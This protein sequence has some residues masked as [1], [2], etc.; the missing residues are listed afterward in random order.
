MAKKTNK[1]EPQELSQPESNIPFTFTW[2]GELKLND[3]VIGKYTNFVQFDTMKL[4]E[5]VSNMVAGQ[6]FNAMVQDKDV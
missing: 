4:T 5:R 3:K 1:V 2:H 6:I